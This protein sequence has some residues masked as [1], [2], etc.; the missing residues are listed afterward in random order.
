MSEDWKEV[1]GD[2]GQIVRWTQEPKNA[3]EAEKT[4]YFGTKIQGIYKKRS[5]NVGMNASTLYEI[6]SPEHGLLS[7]WTTTVLGAKMDE[8]NIG[9]EVMIEC[10][11]PQEA[12]KGGKGYTGFSVKSRPAPM[13]EVGADSPLGELDSDPKLPDM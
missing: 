10:L 4:A 12:K 1:S 13:T 5:D 6:Q 7:V 11:G 3:K 2:L 8:V 9:D